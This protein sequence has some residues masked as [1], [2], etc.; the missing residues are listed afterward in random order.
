[1]RKSHF[2]F[3]THVL[4]FIYLLCF[5]S[6]PLYALDDW[7]VSLDK[8]PSGKYDFLVY[9]VSWNPGFC[10]TQKSIITNCTNQF[11]VHGIWPYYKT[12]GRDNIRNYHPSYCYNSRGCHSFIDCDISINTIKKIQQDK[13][14]SAL[15]PRNDNLFKHEWKK[16]GTCS[17]LKQ[18]QYF[19]QAQ[20]Y[21][22]SA[23]P[24]LRN[25]FNF[26]KRHKNESVSVSKLRKRLPKNV[27]LWCK[28]YNG[29]NY[30]YEVNFFITK[31]G[32]KFLKTNT[33]IG[34]PCTNQVTLA[35][36]ESKIAK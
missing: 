30:L 8:A 4:I 10:A 35:W 33:Q 24:Y 21:K 19:K 13:T 16:H 7:E 2:T 22:D 25:L 26:I 11:K 27:S 28:K 9:A 34:D 14:L 12:D 15:Y 32:N 18:F 31:K 6:W 5:S 23:F 1:M 20:K 17:G 3:F 36:S 29:K